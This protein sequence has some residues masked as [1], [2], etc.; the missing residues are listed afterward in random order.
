MSS[1]TDLHSLLSDMSTEIESK[2][3]GSQAEFARLSTTEP[4]TID[5]VTYIR[6]SSCQ[7]IEIYRCISV[8]L[9]YLPVSSQAFNKVLFEMSEEGAEPQDKTEEAGVPLKL[10]INRPFFFSVTEGNSN[11]ILMLGKVTN[12]TLWGYNPNLWWVWRSD[13]ISLWCSTIKLY[14][15]KLKFLQ[16]LKSISSNIS[17]RSHPRFPPELMSAESR[18]WS[19]LTHSRRIHQFSAVLWWFVTAAKLTNWWWLEWQALRIHSSVFIKNLLLWT[20]LNRIKA[21]GWKHTFVSS[22]KFI[23]AVLFCTVFFHRVGTVGTILYDEWLI[24]WILCWQEFIFVLLWFVI[25]EIKH[26]F[27]S[28]V[29]MSI[30]LSLFIK[31]IFTTITGHQ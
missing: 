16:G 10:T 31:S 11:A 14:P 18:K 4:F 3:L 7:I 9:T 21:A 12:P 15:L 8:S 5:K 27:L 19:M 25:A 2:L 28:V 17:F 26:L 24:L 6:W 23:I 29:D 22:V 1:L 13:L 20:E 30:C